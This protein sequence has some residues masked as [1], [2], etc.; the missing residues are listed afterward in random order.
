MKSI[1][2]HPNLVTSFLL[3]PPSSLQIVAGSGRQRR[4]GTGPG[5]W[6]EHGLGVDGEAATGAG[7][8]VDRWHRGGSS[9]RGRHKVLVTPHVSKPHYYVN[10][11]F[12]RL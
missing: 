11:M 3:L 5:W 7:G 4:V 8:V 9:V 12:M 6:V 2:E 10:H 1:F